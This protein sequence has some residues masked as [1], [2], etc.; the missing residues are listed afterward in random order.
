MV[1]LQNSLCNF[2][3]RIIGTCLQNN[4]GGGGKHVRLLIGGHNS[5]LNFVVLFGTAKTATFF[6]ALTVSIC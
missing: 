1:L 4:G 6:S 5:K 2:Y 3:V